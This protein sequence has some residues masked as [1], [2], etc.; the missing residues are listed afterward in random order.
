MV[1]CFSTISFTLVFN[2]MLS[3]YY[4]VYR[5]VRNCQ[6]VSTYSNCCLFVQM[7]L[8][9]ILAR[10]YFP[11]KLVYWFL[12]SLGSAQFIQSL[13]GGVRFNLALGKSNINRCNEKSNGHRV[14]RGV[15]KTLE[16]DLFHEASHTFR[17]CSFMLRMSTR[18]FQCIFFSEYLLHI[19][20]K[21][22]LCL[23]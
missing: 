20:L 13:F 6:T 21:Y 1:P 15:I 17:V 12:D 14:G 9:R 16:E 2:R 3:I 19:H 10:V 11:L 23:R 7:F 22:F 5:F 18:S 8:S 4:R